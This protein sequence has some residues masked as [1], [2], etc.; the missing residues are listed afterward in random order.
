MTTKLK[1]AKAIAE[2]RGIVADLKSISN[3]LAEMETVS[4]EFGFLDE[5]KTASE[6]LDELSGAFQ[7]LEGELS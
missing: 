5:W 4:E 3:Q 1:Q 2:I 7:K 6:S